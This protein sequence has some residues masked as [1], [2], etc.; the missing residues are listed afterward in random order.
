[1]WSGDG[2]LAGSEVGVSGCGAFSVKETEAPTFNPRQG[3]SP[4]RVETQ[5]PVSVTSSSR[6]DNG[7]TSWLT[8]GR[9]S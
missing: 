6:D 5:I 7:I 9:P 1:M 8:Q 4:T 2:A 3:E